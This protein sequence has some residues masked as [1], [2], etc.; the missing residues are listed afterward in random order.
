ML[1]NTKT[2]LSIKINVRPSGRT[3]L[4]RELMKEVNIKILFKD[5]YI[6]SCPKSDLIKSLEKGVEQAIKDNRQYFK[7]YYVTVDGDL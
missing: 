1:T 2:I 6:L 7:E 3:I 4:R 5:E